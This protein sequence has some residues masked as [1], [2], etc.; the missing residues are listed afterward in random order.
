MYM[1]IPAALL[2]LAV[3]SLLAGCGD[4]VRCD[5]EQDRKLAEWGTPDETE[6]RRDGHLLTETWFY[7]ETKRSVVFLWDERDCS[8]SVSEYTIEADGAAAA[9]LHFETAGRATGGRLGPQ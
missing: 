2:A 1:R 8:C 9:T 3:A 6:S 5:Q 7:R 4:C